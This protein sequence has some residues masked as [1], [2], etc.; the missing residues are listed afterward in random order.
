MPPSERQRTRAQEGV[1]GYLFQKKHLSVL[2][3]RLSLSHRKAMLFSL[4]A[5][6]D[7][8]QGLTPAPPEAAGSPPLANLGRRATKAPRRSSASDNS[9]EQAQRY[10]ALTPRHGNA[11]LTFFQAPRAGGSC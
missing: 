1:A 3:Y 4:R 6:G 11:G 7:P 9:R 5:I 2:E 10:R 8:R